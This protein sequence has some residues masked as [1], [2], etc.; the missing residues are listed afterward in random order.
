MID[1]ADPDYYRILQVQP[2]AHPSIIRAAYHQLAKL[3][4]PDVSAAPDES[5]RVMQAINRAYETLK[6]PHARA[7]YD[8]LVRTR[9]WATP[10]DY[11]P[12]PPP[13]TPAAPAIITVKRSTRIFHDH[14]TVH[15]NPP[16]STMA[17]TAYQLQWLLLPKSPA[18]QWRDT[19]E[20]P[21]PG[22]TRCALKRTQMYTRYAF[23]IR[24]YTTAGPGPWS[25]SFK[26][27]N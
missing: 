12:H 5:H 4:H 23:R 21:N 14:V 3:H 18:S 15:W 26:E 10:Q 6:D 17:I 25:R 2:D 9:N 7:A 24:A 13:R 8:R 1:S 16:D 27:V 19:P 11:V 20:Q 22:A